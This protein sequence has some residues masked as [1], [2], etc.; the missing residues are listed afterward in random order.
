MDSFLYPTFRLSTDEGRSLTGFK[1]LFQIEQ[2]EERDQL[3]HRSCPT[4]L[5]GHAEPR[6]VIPVEVL[7]GEVATPF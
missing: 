3:G 6:A 5:V 4:R 1:R 7:I 2:S